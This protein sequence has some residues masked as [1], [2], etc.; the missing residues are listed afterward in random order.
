M[1]TSFVEWIS[2]IGAFCFGIVIGWITYRTLRRTPTTGLNDIATVIGAVGGATVTALFK[3]GT[4]DFGA[5]CIGL[6]IGFFCYLKIAA[7]KGA[8]DWMGSE[9]AGSPGGSV[10]GVVIR[11]PQSPE[12]RR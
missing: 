7:R 3:Q 2:L 8:P 4:G 1:P 11:P 10:G 12:P 9:Q 6:I 5:Y